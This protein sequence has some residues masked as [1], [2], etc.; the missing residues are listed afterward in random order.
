MSAARTAIRFLPPTSNQ[1]ETS[2]AKSTSA[3]PGLL[4]QQAE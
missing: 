2:S 4:P 3:T 1:R